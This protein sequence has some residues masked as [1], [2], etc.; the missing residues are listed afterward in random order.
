MIV[1]RTPFVT[2][3]YFCRQNQQNILYNEKNLI[4]LNAD[5]GGS[6]LFWTDHQ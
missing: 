2:F 5:D 4:I 6:V 1:L 3:Y